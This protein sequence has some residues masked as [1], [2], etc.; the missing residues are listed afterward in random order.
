MKLIRRHMLTGALAAAFLPAAPAIV[1]A[2]TA[3]RSIDEFA[4]ARE[5]RTKTEAQADWT[6][7][8]QTAV[9]E[10]A[11][12]AIY[13]P[14]G[15][16]PFRTYS[17]FVVDANRCVYNNPNQPRSIDIACDP[18][19]TFIVGGIKKGVRSII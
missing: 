3:R 4:G 17:G 18:D 19:A 15:N 10:G 13:V 5:M 11:S 1:K 7:V 8:F 2:A 9:N 12:T 14:P 16:Y 6:P